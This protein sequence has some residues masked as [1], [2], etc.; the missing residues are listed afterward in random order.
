MQGDTLG[1][2]DRPFKSRNARI[3]ADYLQEQMQIE[4]RD[5]TPLDDI[6]AE[7]FP[8][9]DRFIGDKQFMDMDSAGLYLGP[10][11]FDFLKHME[12]ILL[13][14]TYVELV[15]YWGVEYAPVRYVNELIGCWG[16]GSGKDMSVQYG[17]ARA[18]N[19]LLSMKSPH[20]YYG[21]P[22]HT[23]IHMMNVA[24]SAPQAH[25]V[26][27]KPLRTL[28]VNS[29]WYADKFL[30][31]PPGEQAGE[32]RF[33]KQ[34]E[35]ISGHSDAET[36]EGKNLIVAVADEIS[37]F[38][39]AANATSSKTAAS[40][41]AE[42]LVD[43]LQSSATTR[44][45]DNFKLVQISYPRAKGDA[46][47]K[48]LEEA[49]KEELEDG[50]D[51]RFYASGPFKTW[52]VNPKFD[53]IERVKV[54]GV[55]DPIPNYK[56]IVKDYKNNIAYAKAKYECDP[57]AAMN[58]YF[59]DDAAIFASFA[60]NRLVPPITFSYRV[61]ID[62]Q[63]DEKVE[64][65]QCD[66]AFSPDFLPAIGA[67]YA[68][69]GDM[70]ITGDR[71]GVAMSHVTGYRWVKDQKSGLDMAVPEVQVDFCNYWEADN[72]AVN[73]SNDEFLA[74]EVQLRWFRKLVLALADRG[75]AIGRVSMDGFQSVD[76]LQ[77]LEA[78]GFVTEKY[79]LDRTPEGY[80]TLRDVMYE[81]RLSGYYDSILVNE[82]AAL[83]QYPNGKID[84]LPG[85]S[86]DLSDAVA[87]SVVGAI[88]CGG[89]EVDLVDATEAIQSLPEPD[90]SGE[91]G[92]WGHA[93]ESFGTF[94][95]NGIQI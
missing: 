86:K 72:A 59:K 53:K 22:S 88:L 68:I 47:L 62:Q 85:G 67:V 51:S 57:D 55:P 16:K 71:A 20:V 50:E 29:P 26:F 60:E 81:G 19:I 6:F 32:I 95:S 74:R 38:P 13:P 42:G 69:H 44:F 8:P 66:F 18:A 58:R 41:T 56:K 1:M 49:K 33:K 91:F 78:R 83:N 37:A 52:D 9:L 30:G 35:L 36:L 14:Q 87:G 61:G 31:K 7:Q 39:L 90:M 89:E 54:A 46:I 25:G 76:S 93:P 12:Q 27:F 84:H 64:Q 65:W 79:S 21:I 10:I 94:G 70:A 34:I 11:Q 48:A 75:F 17:F 3:F 28:L 63:N 24:A 80:K 4:D 43:M 2:A 92:G 82:I 77:I 40:R 5:L 73:P 45:P 23:I 15:R